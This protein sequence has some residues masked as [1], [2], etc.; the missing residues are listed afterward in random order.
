MIIQIPTAILLVSIS[1]YIL[2]KSLDVWQ[3]AVSSLLSSFSFGLK[4]VSPGTDNEEE[5]YKPKYDVSAFT[6]RM[7]KLRD[8]VDEDGLFYYPLPQQKSDETGTEVITEAY[9]MDIDERTRR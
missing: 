3:N 8:E 5:Q 6:Q 7:K 2:G 4:G 9:E 1:I